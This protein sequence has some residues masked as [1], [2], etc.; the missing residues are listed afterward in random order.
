MKAKVQGERYKVKRERVKEIR[1]WISDDR[2]GHL[3]LE[4]SSLK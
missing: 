1:E 4:I 2:K 3:G